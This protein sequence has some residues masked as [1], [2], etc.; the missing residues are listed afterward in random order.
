MTETTEGEE[1]LPCQ[2]GG[3]MPAICPRCGA[4]EDDTCMIDRPRAAALSVAD[5]IENLRSIVAWCRRRLPPLLQPCV[6]RMLAGE[7]PDA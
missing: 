7:K 5:E 1:R 4:T 2:Q 6:D 3:P